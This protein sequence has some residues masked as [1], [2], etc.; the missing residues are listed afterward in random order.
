M[1]SHWDGAAPQ[2]RVRCNPLTTKHAW[3]TVR[4]VRAA[5][6]KVT[7]LYKF[8]NR[9]LIDYLIAVKPQARERPASAASVSRGC[10]AWA[11]PGGGSNGWAARFSLA[12]AR[13]RRTMTK[14]RPRRYEQRRCG[15]AFTAV[16]A[17]RDAPAAAPVQRRGIPFGARHDPQSHVCPDHV[18]EQE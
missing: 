2:P 3:T 11:R 16:Q 7:P 4:N 9:L 8:Y 15:E 1:P 10:R 13:S 14:S 5:A 6:K 18:F 17:S 12:V